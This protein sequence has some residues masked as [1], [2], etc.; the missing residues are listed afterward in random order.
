MTFSNPKVFWY[1]DD[2]K[3]SHEI[4]VN[5][6]RNINCVDPRNLEG[7]TNFKVKTTN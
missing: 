6:Y 4:F 1:E 5:T 7:V 2:M 3:S